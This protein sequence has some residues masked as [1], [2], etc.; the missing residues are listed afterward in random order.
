V[1]LR[2]YFVLSL[3]YPPLRLSYIFALYFIHHSTKSSFFYIDPF[4]N[5]NIIGIK[6]MM[7]RGR[8]LKKFEILT[9]LKKGKVVAVVRAESEEDAYQISM[10]CIG[11]GIKNIEV[12]FT[13]PN[14]VDVIKRLSQNNNLNAVIGAGTVLDPE[15]TRLAILNGARYIVSPHFSK[16]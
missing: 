11:G 12:T 15:T 3:V 4:I 1:C 16:E 7:R 10:A 13:T 8:M 6:L 5:V 2:N 9:E 14:A